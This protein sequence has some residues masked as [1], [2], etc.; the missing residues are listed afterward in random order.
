MGLFDVIGDFFGGG[1]GGNTTATSSSTTSTQQVSDSYNS[2]NYSVS[3]ATN[4]IGNGGAMGTNSWIATGSGNIL[5]GGSV[6]T[7]GNVTFGD[8]TSK[9]PMLALVIA[10]AVALI[11]LWKR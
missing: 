10:G 8:T 9:L 11:F 6:N 5:S 2:T 3:N 7:G 4:N 1:G